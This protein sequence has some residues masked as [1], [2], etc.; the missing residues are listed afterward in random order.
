VELRD[1]RLLKVPV[2][3]EPPRPQVELLSKG[4]QGDAAVASPVH[5][6]SPT[7]CPDGRLVFFLKSASRQKLSAH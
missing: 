7:T 3:V 4:T 5:L 1:G 6:G 2:T